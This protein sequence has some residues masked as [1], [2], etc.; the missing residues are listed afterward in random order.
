MWLGL[1]SV[2]VECQINV[3]LRSEKI[4]SAEISSTTTMWGNCHGST[5]NQKLLNQ[6]NVFWTGSLC[7]LHKQNYLAFLWR[8]TEP[9]TITTVGQIQVQHRACVIVKHWERVVC[10][11]GSG[12]RCL[13]T[14]AV[15]LTYFLINQL[16]RDQLF[17][18]LQFK[19]TVHPVYMM[20]ACNSEQH[21]IYDLWFML[22]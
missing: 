9:C 11:P 5:S 14:S 3:F 4:L 8:H 18:T 20:H 1:Y 13:A 22:L 21:F 15:H 19:V 17:L 16:Y 6:V 10:V 7:F 12:R 2:Y